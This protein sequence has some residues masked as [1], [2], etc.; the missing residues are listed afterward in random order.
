MEDKKVIDYTYKMNKTYNLKVNGC[1]EK[2]PGDGRNKSQYFA[3]VLK[4]ITIC[5]IIYGLWKMRLE[6][7][8]AAL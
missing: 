8:P 7:N 6:K 1:K 3:I 4:I 5:S 2:S